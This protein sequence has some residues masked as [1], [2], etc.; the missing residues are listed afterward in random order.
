MIDKDGD[1]ILTC[2][3]CRRYK[4]TKNMILKVNLWICNHCSL[5]LSKL[6]KVGKNEGFRFIFWYW[7]F[8]SEPSKAYNLLMNKYTYKPP[9]SESD[10][11]DAY[12]SGLTQ[13]ECANKFNVSQKVIWTAMRWFGIKARVASK[14][15]QLGRN[16]SSWKGDK[17]GKKA[18]HRRLYS[19]HGKP[20]K[21]EKCKTEDKT[22]AYDYANLT[23][24]YHD[25][26]DYMPMCRSCHWVYD[27]KILNIK[28]MRGR[29]NNA[30]E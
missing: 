15:N 7:R 13:V 2:Y 30:G 3:R 17:A 1:K 9:C 6:K 24:N 4:K 21:C 18:F 12:N 8:D 20:K 25:I 14:R 29:K 19:L 23:G 28:K 26:N 16:N 11:S 22:R 5:A 10:L 27:R